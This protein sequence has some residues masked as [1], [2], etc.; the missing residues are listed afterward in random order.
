MTLVILN[1]TDVAFAGSAQTPSRLI[2]RYLAARF[3]FNKRLRTG[4]RLTLACDV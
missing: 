1:W 3:H 4:E 2:Y